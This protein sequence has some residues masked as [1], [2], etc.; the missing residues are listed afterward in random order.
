LNLGARQSVYRD[1]ISLV[2]AITDLLKTQ[3]Q[4]TQLDVAGIQQRVLTKR[5][6]Q[7]FYAGLT[8]HYGRSEK[9]KDKDTEKS[10]PYEDPQ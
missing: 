10:I 6:S 4:D 3:R 1:Q 7:I 9:G 2:L 8:Y 5:D